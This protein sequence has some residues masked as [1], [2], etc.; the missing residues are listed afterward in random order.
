MTTTTQQ[1]TD[2][3]NAQIAALKNEID[4]NHGKR[5]NA[6]RR[7]QLE[8]LYAKHSRIIGYSEQVRKNLNSQNLPDP[9]SEYKIERSR[10]LIDTSAASEIVRAY[11]SE[12]TLKHPPTF[13]YCY[14]SEI[15]RCVMTM[16]THPALRKFAAWREANDV[17]QRAIEFGLLDEAGI[18]DTGSSRRRSRWEAVN[19]DIYS[20]THDGKLI[21]VQQRESESDG[22]YT[23]VKI[24]YFVTDGERAIEIVNGKKQIIKRAATADAAPDSPLRALRSILPAE[25]QEL[26]DGTPV[27]LAGTKR[28][29]GTG[30][31]LLEMAEDGTLRSLWSADYQYTLGKTKMQKAREDHRGGLYYY[32]TPDECKRLAA[33]NWGRT[34][35]QFAL[36][37]CEVGGNTIEYDS[38]K[39]ASTYL[40][41]VE[42][43]ETIAA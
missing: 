22:R 42:V 30:Y 8:A 36:V 1:V 13:D 16:T 9:R 17:L 20:Y 14:S 4:A 10:K 7:T 19:H 38:G 34:I 15:E 32:R 39:R 12:L 24:R 43:V 33:G 40:R 37:R 27:K 23:N 28:A 5:G 6:E 11:Y 25:W 2:R 3:I 41:P 29:T 21:V 31:K 18:V 26:I 35:A